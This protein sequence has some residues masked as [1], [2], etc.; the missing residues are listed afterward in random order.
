MDQL[1]FNDQIII[2]NFRTQAGPKH[3]SLHGDINRMTGVGSKTC[4][5]QYAPPHIFQSWGHESLNVKVTV[6]TQH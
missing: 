1:R 6:Y 2:W 5:K 3:A 4:Q